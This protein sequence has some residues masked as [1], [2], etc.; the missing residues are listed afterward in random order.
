MNAL[1]RRASLANSAKDLR[2]RNPSSHLPSQSDLRHNCAAPRETSANA[3]IKGL[4]A[5]HRGPGLA[6]RRTVA[7]RLTP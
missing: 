1:G 5:V 2:L 3:V 7:R 6:S 4:L